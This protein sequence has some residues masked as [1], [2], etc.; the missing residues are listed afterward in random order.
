M[1]SVIYDLKF[2]F[3]LK[4]SALHALIH[5][6]DKI[7][8]QLV[9]GDFACGIFVDLQKAVDH[10]ILRQKLNHY[11][12]R[13]VA[14][15]CFLSFL[16]NRS[17]YD[18]INGLNS[19]LEHIHCGVLQG[20]IIEP[21]LFFIFINDLYCAIRYCS[22]H[23]ILDEE[24]LLNNKNSV[25]RRNK[26]VNQDLKNLRNWLNA[27]KI[28]LNVS[29]TKFVLFK[30]LGKLTNV[31]LK[32]KLNG[33]RLY[34][35]NSVKYL[36]NID[37]KLNWKQQ[38][39]NIAIKLNK[40]NGVSSKLRHFIDRTTLKSIYH[41]IFEPHLYYSSLVWTQISNSVKRL[42]VLQK[43]FLW[44]IY[45]LNNNAHASPLFRELN[46]LKLPDGISQENCLF[47]NK[48]FNKCLCTI[49]K[50]WFTISSDF[51]TYSTC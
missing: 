40:A 12:I 36:I 13:G 10:D 1:N 48:Y 51:H 35:T 29:K 18:S 16:Q 42:F 21:S 39:S 38:I 4:Y 27:N 37:E 7:R 34:P 32:L 24:N 49:F 14:K 26:Q 44:I 3:R 6:P 8:Q 5:I 30:S 33:K 25:K 20:S 11:G 23:H 2:G 46:I 45:F 47:I 22:V 15:I 28:F 31:P 41:A 17:Q 43:K 50:N 19:K 9:N